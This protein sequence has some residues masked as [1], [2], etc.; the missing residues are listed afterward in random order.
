VLLPAIVQGHPFN[1][2]YSQTV[3]RLVKA[4]SQA[5]V[6]CLICVGKPFLN[7]VISHRQRALEIA[8]TLKVDHPEELKKIAM[9]YGAENLNVYVGGYA[10]ISSSLEAAKKKRIPFGQYLNDYAPYTTEEALKSRLEG[11]GFKILP[12]DFRQDHNGK[13]VNVFSGLLT[14]YEEI[15]DDLVRGKERVLVEH[16]AVQLVQMEIDSEAG[17]RSVFVSNDRKLRRA[18]LL[19]HRTRDRVSSILP[20]ESFVGLV[21]IVVGSRPDPRGLARLV[22]ASP[23]READQIVRDYLVKRALL[24]QDVAQAKASAEVI[25]EIVAEARQE[26]RV[27]PVD[28]ANGGTAE[29]V[30]EAVDFIDRFEDRFFE[31]MRQAIE[32]Q[33]Q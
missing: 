8:D 5:G 21:D 2:L 22:W 15:K 19:D 1:K 16:E 6:D 7:E 14:G 25:S 26:M 27:R 9:L 4:A 32:R 13:Y 18:A 12:M 28:L 30:G 20:P 24:E 10:G 31:K 3:E 23:R 33:E 17:L 11:R 29:A